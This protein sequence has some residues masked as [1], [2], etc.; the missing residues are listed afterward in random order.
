MEMIH[1]QDQ[2]GTISDSR[3]QSYD[4]PI[5]KPSNDRLEQFLMSVQSRL[6]T[7]RFPKQKVTLRQHDRRKGFG[8]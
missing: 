7:K 1:R 8:T 2:S 3:D 5:P 6:V 4:I